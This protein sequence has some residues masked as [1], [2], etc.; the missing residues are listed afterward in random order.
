MI[1]DRIKLLRNESGLTVEELADGIL[2]PKYI[3]DIENNVRHV[4][5][6]ILPELAARLGTSVDSLLGIE[7]ETNIRKANEL[8]DSALRYAYRELLELAKENIVRAKELEEHFSTELKTKLII[9][10]CQV[11]IKERKVKEAYELIESMDEETV[12]TFNDLY[13]IYL[14]VYG[15]LY[16]FKEEY[17]KAIMSLHSAINVKVNFEKYPF[18]VGICYFNLGITYAFIGNLS[19]GEQHLKKAESIFQ[20]IG[21]IKQLTDTY[22]N[23]GNIY[24]RRDDYEDALD[25]YKKAQN[26]LIYNSD[27]KTSSYIFHNIGLVYLKLNNNNKAI[28]F[29]NRALALKRKVGSFPNDLVNSIEMLARCHLAC[30]D[31]ELAELHIKEILTYIP[32]HDSELGSLYKAN[33]YGTVG[34]YHKAIGDMEKYIDYTKLSQEI[35]KNAELYFNAAKSAYELGQE[36]ND[37]ELLV[38][39]ARLFYQYH[40]KLKEK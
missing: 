27:L 6:D 12:K 9:V 20:D 38:E 2:S 1:G 7:K 3:Q 8:L 25:T 15:A 16:F 39:S 19:W 18:E 33:C 22:I 28:E 37:Q 31:Y 10:E 21:E 4:P 14:R 24:F 26:L 30:K 29:G 35:Y 40:I 32:K 5:D 13:F 23:L 36:L 17:W 34:L 11:L